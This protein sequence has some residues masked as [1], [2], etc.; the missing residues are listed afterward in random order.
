MA[1]GAALCWRY[2]DDVRIDHEN[3]AKLVAAQQMITSVDSLRAL[4]DMPQIGAAVTGGKVLVH[5]LQH[6]SDTTSI[7][8]G[9]DRTDYELALG[10]L[11]EIEALVSKQQ[12]SVADSYRP[13]LL[14]FCNDQLSRAQNIVASSQS[15]DHFPLFAATAILGILL[16]GCLMA[17]LLS[18]FDKAATK[19]LSILQ[20]NAE[21][22]QHGI[23]LNTMFSG[24]DGFASLDRRFHDMAQSLDKAQERLKRGENR[25]RLVL[26]NMPVGVLIATIDGVIE[27]ANP[28]AYETFGSMAGRLSSRS[29]S[30]LFKLKEHPALTSIADAG[31]T[32]YTVGTKSNGTEFSAALN[33]T[34]YHDDSEDKEKLLVSF[35]DITWRTEL[36][37]MKREFMAMISHDI[38]TP[39]TSISATLGML[40]AG[41]WGNLSEKALKAIENDEDSLDHIMRLLNDLLSIEKLASGTFQL[42]KKDTSSEKIIKRA[43]A[44]VKPTALARRVDLVVPPD[45]FDLWLDEDRM[46]QLITNL[47]TNA[48]KFS[49]E[50]GTVT[51]AVQD[52]TDQTRFEISDQ[53]PGIAA[54]DQEKIFDKFGQVKSVD[55]AGAKGM[56]LGL[57]I[58]K[59]I[60]EQHGGAIGVNSVPD[61]GTTFWVNIPKRTK[62]ILISEKSEES[63]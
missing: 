3:T 10:D 25:L 19:R 62:T 7:R 33:V 28:K 29:V 22:L 4:L 14:S 1:I 13:H 60:A 30:D 47:L 39:L 58:S 24:T 51:I 57:A 37:K 18:M 35:E 45:N 42:E 20:D 21:R 56:G 38:R 5:Q 63:C 46:V 12:I 61:K 2:A 27:S 15:T 54:D 52:D 55:F 16:N 8:N 49:P 23:P 59:Q 17:W 32:I 26:E 11:K 6:I 31:R 34:R 41:A 44:V 9:F 40:A 43:V 53:G 48:V 50:G 36:E